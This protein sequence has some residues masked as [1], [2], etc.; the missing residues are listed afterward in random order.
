MC[1]ALN[2]LKLGAE[3]HARIASLA[4]EAPTLILISSGKKLSRQKIIPR[5]EGG[6]SLVEILS[7]S[8]LPIAHF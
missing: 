4:D 1:I 8:Q 7:T 3:L 2:A 6:A 5:H